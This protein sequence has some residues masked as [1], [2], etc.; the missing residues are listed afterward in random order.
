MKNILPAPGVPLRTAMKQ[1][2]KIIRLAPCPPLRCGRRA[3]KYGGHEA[4]LTWESSP[5]ND[6]I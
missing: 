3:R 5:T 2:T 4:W 1:K 6:K